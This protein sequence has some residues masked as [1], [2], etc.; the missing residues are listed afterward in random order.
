MLVGG[1][2]HLKV[3]IHLCAVASSELPA[4]LHVFGWVRYEF[5]S[6]VVQSIACRYRDFTS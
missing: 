3:I 2:T 5:F 6:Q 1:L 4:A